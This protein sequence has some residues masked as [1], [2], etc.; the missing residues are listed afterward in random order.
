MGHRVAPEPGLAVEVRQIS[1]SAR[2]K[3][4]M[5]NVL[6]RSLHAPF[7][8]AP[9]WPARLGGEVIVAAKFEQARMKV[10]G[11]ATAFE[12]HGFKVVIENSSGRAG[13]GA[14]GMHMAQQKVLQCL[15][16][17]KLQ[18][19]R[20]AVGESEHEAGETTLGTADGN[21]PEAGPVTLSLLAW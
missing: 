10:N 20:A 13:P 9:E 5:A 15:V 1:K 7:F 19:E 8:G 21:R 3:E 18:I 16:E 6:D 14:K 4:G 2:R 11:V 17:K 12:H